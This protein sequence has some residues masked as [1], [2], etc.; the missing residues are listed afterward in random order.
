MRAASWRTATIAQWLK[1]LDD[2]VK[3]RKAEDNRKLYHDN[4]VKVYGLK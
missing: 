3:D 1:A 4:A 2:V